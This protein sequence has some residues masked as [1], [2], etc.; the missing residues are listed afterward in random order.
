MDLD[1]PGFPL[2]NGYRAGPRAPKQNLGHL[3]E[4]QGHF[5]SSL[6]SF[7][8]YKYSETCTK[9]LVACSPHG[10]CGAPILFRPKQG[11]PGIAAFPFA[12]RT[13]SRRRTREYMKPSHEIMC[14]N[15]ATSK[16][17]FVRELVR[18]G[19]GDEC[20]FYNTNSINHATTAFHF[21]NNTT[22]SCSHF[23][24]RRGAYAAGL[25]APLPHAVTCR[26]F[27]GIRVSGYVC[28]APIAGGDTKSFRRRVQHHQHATRF[29]SPVYL[30]STR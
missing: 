8:E 14:G 15:V 28:S 6:S 10:T 21:P 9:Q 11:E 1:S 18:S 25:C 13:R 23:I 20:T 5:C 27:V 17:V 29:R 24:C 4:Q 7:F 19:T 2:Q 22:T 12:V 3:L 26:H 16:G 30:V